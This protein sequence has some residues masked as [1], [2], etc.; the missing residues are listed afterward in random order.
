MQAVGRWGGK[1]LAILAAATCQLRGRKELA[2]IVHRL[3]QKPHL[4]RRA[5]EPDQR[6]G[7]HRPIPRVVSKCALRES[8]ASRYLPSSVFC[9]PNRISSS[10]FSKSGSKVAAFGKTLSKIAPSWISRRVRAFR[11][12]TRF[13]AWASSSRCCACFSCFSVSV[14]MPNLSVKITVFAS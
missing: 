10:F 6:K 13:L 1:S 9:T 14:K 8:K 3:P 7:Y 5:H 12:F 2:R 4:P 11:S